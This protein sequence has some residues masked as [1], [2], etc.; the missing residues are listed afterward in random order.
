[1]RSGARCSCEREFRF[2]GSSRSPPTATV[3]VASIREFLGPRVSFRGETYLRT[4][5]TD[6]RFTSL[7]RVAVADGLS[8][9][10]G[11]F[12]S[13]LDALLSLDYQVTSEPRGFW[14]EELDTAP[15]SRSARWGRDPR[16]RREGQRAGAWLPFSGAPLWLLALGLGKWPTVERRESRGGCPVTLGV[17]L[18]PRVLMG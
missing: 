11:S 5:V 18:C 1:M 2:L 12:L 3:G 4:T 16:L 13:F 6:P 8:C 9:S 7:W 17:P 10:L 15:R 14:R